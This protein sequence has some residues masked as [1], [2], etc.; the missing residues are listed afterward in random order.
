MPYIYKQILEYLLLKKKF[1]EEVVP[2]IPTAHLD[3]KSTLEFFNLYYRRAFLY[4][5]ENRY[6]KAER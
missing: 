4:A 1:A 5:K 2:L 3:G 6:N